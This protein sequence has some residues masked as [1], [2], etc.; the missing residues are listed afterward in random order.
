MRDLHELHAKC[1][2]S[3]ARVSVHVSGMEN[4]AS[5][6]RTSVI[7]KAAMAVS[8]L[9]IAGWLTI[10][11][12]ANLLVFGDPSLMNGYALKL[13]AT[14]LLWPE[15]AVMLGVLLIHVV[16]AVIT[17]RRS[18]AAR[19]APYRVALRAQRS[20]LASRTM[21]VGGSLLA[22]YLL[23]HVAHLYGVGHS[24]YI[25]GDVFH[26]LVSA[27]RNPLHAALYTLASGLLA[28]H[29]SHG[30]HSALRSLGG[31]DGYREVALRRVLRGWTW[32]VCI[33]FAV[34]GIAVGTGLL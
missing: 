30:I 14:G 34:P 22:A 24:S 5:I 1:S 29:L 26:N 6:L 18:H 21:R 13:R 27:L 12:L 16:A 28:L 4:L 10:H 9:L 7:V 23:Y 17:T 33:G 8:G 32:V 2:A 15:R 11:M 25:P 31:L 3:R 20:T 19:P